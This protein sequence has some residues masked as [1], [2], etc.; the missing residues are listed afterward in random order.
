MIDIQYLSICFL[1]FLTITALIACSG[2]FFTTFYQAGFPKSLSAITF[3]ASGF[4][5][6]F[7]ITFGVQFLNQFALY[8]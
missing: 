4:I 3:T 7:S 1:V 2:Y 6:Y 8:L 5:A